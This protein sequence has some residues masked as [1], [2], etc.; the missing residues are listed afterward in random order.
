MAAGIRN[1][2]EVN[3]PLPSQPS[4]VISS[5]ILFSRRHDHDSTLSEGLRDGNARFCC[6]TNVL[7]ILTTAPR[8]LDVEVLDSLTLLDDSGHTFL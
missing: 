4:G 7:N 6:V 2:C 5:N 3:S 1:G 8:F